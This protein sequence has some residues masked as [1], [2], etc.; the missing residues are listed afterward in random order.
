MIFIFTHAFN[1]YIANS[2]SVFELWNQLQI[3]SVEAQQA[4]VLIP[5]APSAFPFI[6]LHR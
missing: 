6:A 2:P 5:A 1:T 4:E 3:L